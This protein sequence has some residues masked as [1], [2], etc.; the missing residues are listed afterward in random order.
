MYRELQAGKGFA[1]IVF[2][3]RTIHADKPAMV[4]ELKWDQDAETAVDQIKQKQYTKS[5]E[6]Y[7]GDVLLVGISYDKKSK[8]HSCVI[9]TYRK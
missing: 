9:E 3:P 4:V 7:S 1:D 5:L 6:Q 8:S 2:L